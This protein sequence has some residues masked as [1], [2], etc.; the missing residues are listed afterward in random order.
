MHTGRKQTLLIALMSLLGGCGTYSLPELLMGLLPVD[1][2]A[3]PASSHRTGAEL[4]RGAHEASDDTPWGAPTEV[5]PPNAWPDFLSCV[6]DPLEAFEPTVL[7]VDLGRE[8]PGVWSA[9]TTYGP[10]FRSHDGAWDDAVPV[11]ETHT[12]FE[13]DV[14]GIG[15]VYGSVA[16]WLLA[17]GVVLRG[18]FS[19]FFEGVDVG[20][21]CWNDDM[22]FGWTQDPLFSVHYDANVGHCVDALGNE[23][24]N[25]VPI[26]IVRERAFAE[27]ADI[28]DT[29]LNGA[30]FGMPDLNGWN[31]AG[32]SLA[33]SRLHFANLRSV[34]MPGADL[35]ALD[36]GYAE[37][38]G[39]VDENTRL[40]ADG[41]CTFTNGYA[42]MAVCRR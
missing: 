24:R 36:F 15:E 7:R 37:I 34:F 28:H 13:D 8:R 1:S 18:A 20:L 30:D 23:A 9:N 41:S 25:G 39:F 31:L 22:L 2:A 21:T 14:G 3:S 10:L 11:G 27:C 12:L 5:V 16:V 26:E 6:T 35:S 40:P 19:D 29:D 33:G 38:D 4:A 42:K 17:D 32:A